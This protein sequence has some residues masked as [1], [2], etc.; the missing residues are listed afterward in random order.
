MNDIS[1]LINN[2]IVCTNDVWKRWFAGR[3]YEAGDFSEVSGALFEAIVCSKM[4]QGAAMVPSTFM[5]SV[6]VKYRRAVNE[7]RQ[8]C[9]VQR[10]GNVFCEPRLVQVHEGDV[11]AV[12]DIDPCG[13]MLD[14]EP[15]VE[16]DRGK[17]FLLED[18]KNLSFWFVTNAS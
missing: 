17:S 3:G 11:F 8:I 4:E 15:Y 2:W 6:A 16:V 13:M 9:V 12:R 14:G 5:Q 18:P 10:A 1:E 7:T